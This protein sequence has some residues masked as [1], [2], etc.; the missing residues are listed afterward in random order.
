MLFLFGSSMY[1]LIPTDISKILFCQIILYCE[2]L[3]S[4]KILLVCLCAF[5]EITFLFASCYMPFQVIQD[6]TLQWHLASSSK[7]ISF[8]SLLKYP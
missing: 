2:Y 6:F 8:N 5:E 7:Y 1:Y 3:Y 4:S